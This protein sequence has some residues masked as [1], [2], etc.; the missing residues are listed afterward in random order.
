M[1][2]RSFLVWLISL[3]VVPSRFIR[4][5]L[6]ITGFPFFLGFLGSHSWYV[7]VPRPGVESELQ[8]LAYTQLQ[9]C[10]I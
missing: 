9:K 4:M 3:G 5:N 7:E 6:E 8:L 10:G 1:S 2:Y